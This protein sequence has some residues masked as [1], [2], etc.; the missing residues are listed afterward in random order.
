MTTTENT[1]KP[2]ANP[3]V[4]NEREAHSL[5]ADVMALFRVGSLLL[6]AEHAQ[7]P[8]IEHGLRLLGQGSRECTRALVWEICNVVREHAENGIDLPPGEE[9]DCLCG[10]DHGNSMDAYNTFLTDAKAGNYQAPV[11]YIDN[12]IGRDAYEDL[13]GWVGMS[14]DSLGNIRYDA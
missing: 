9:S 6:K 7:V 13:L 11:D 14:A 4:N 8:A 12:I 10:R 2:T 1:F 3:Y 5:N